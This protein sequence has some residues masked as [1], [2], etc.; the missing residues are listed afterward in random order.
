MRLGLQGYCALQTL[1]LNIRTTGSRKP[2]S[3]LVHNYRAHLKPRKNCGANSCRSKQQD[4]AGRLCPVIASAQFSSASV[5]SF[6]RD[7]CVCCICCLSYFGT[8]RLVKILCVSLHVGLLHSAILP[9]YRGTTTDVGSLVV[10][11][12]AALSPSWDGLGLVA[13]FDKKLCLHALLV[14]SRRIIVAKACLAVR[15]LGGQLFVLF[16]T[17]VG[18]QDA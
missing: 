5:T 10:P 8:P 17:H 14:G 13:H 2:G 12:A 1:H 3:S 18:P 4:A 9:R 11:P 7:P 16:Q 6:A 15:N